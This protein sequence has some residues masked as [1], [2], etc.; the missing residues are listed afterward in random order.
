MK[1]MIIGL[2]VLWS[3]LG[4]AIADHGSSGNGGHN[5]GGLHGSYQGGRGS[6][7]WPYYADD[8]IMPFHGVEYFDYPYHY[9]VDENTGYTVFMTHDG[10]YYYYSDIDIWDNE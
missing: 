9:V 8:Y 1:A 10:H 5:G 4:F 3:G 2:C 6:L 7:H